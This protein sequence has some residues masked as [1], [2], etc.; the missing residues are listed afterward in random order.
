MGRRQ[1]LPDPLGDGFSVAEARRYGVTH[2]RM[3]GGDLLRPFHGMRVIESEIDEPERIDDPYL[4]QRRDRVARARLYAPRLHTGHFFSH[5][6]AA[7]IWGG[8][9]PLEFTEKG[10]V[11]DG[12][13]LPLHVSA[14]GFVPFPRARGIVGHRTL[15]SMTSI[16][17]CDDLR[18]TSPAATWVSLGRLRV[19]DLVALGDYFCRKWRTGVGRRE[20][21]RAPLA[22]L[23]DLQAALNAGRRLGAARLRDALS[24]IREDSWSPRESLVRVI[25]V[26]A[27]LPEPQLNIDVFDDQGR[28]LG[29]ADMVYPEARVIVE[30]HGMLHGPQWAQDVER[31]GA[32]RAAGWDVIEVTSP[33]LNRPEELVQRVRRALLG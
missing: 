26:T 15:A 31:I 32:F 13:L 9:L 12:E 17:E 29:C 20:V 8:P 18:V 14:S 19:P 28:F 1:E 22:T 4:R 3:R 24:L 7:S 2:A 33:L 27:G 16:G 23:D 21:G 11:A 30:Y 5:Q 25:L 10:E 6:T